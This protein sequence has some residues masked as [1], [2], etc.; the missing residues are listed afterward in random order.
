MFWILPGRI[1]GHCAAAR[2]AVKGVCASLPRFSVEREAHCVA[3]QGVRA[4][5]LRF[6]AERE[7]HML[8]YVPVGANGRKAFQEHHECPVGGHHALRAHFADA[9]E[10]WCCITLRGRE[11]Q[12]AEDPEEVLFAEFEVG[13]ELDLFEITVGFSRYEGVIAE[14]R[15]VREECRRGHVDEE[16]HGDVSFCV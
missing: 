11:A 7:T 12:C 1:S 4:R 10:F 8:E 6:S 3:A 15:Y 13:L 5:L 16:E 14:A 9:Q 2:L